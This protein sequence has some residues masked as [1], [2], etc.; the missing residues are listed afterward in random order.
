[1]LS[2]TVLVRV[3]GTKLRI[4]GPQ[5][6]VQGENAEFVIT[7]LNSSDN[8]I[9]GRSVDV[10][11]L[12]GN[13]ISADSL[14]TDSQGRVRITLTATQAGEDELSSSAL[15]A[16]TELPIEVSPAGSINFV[17]PEESAEIPIN[18]PQDVK[19]AAPG[20]T[21]TVSFSSTRGILSATTAQLEDEV[22]DGILT[23]TAT[24]TVNASTAGPA[25]LTAR[26]GT[27]GAEIQRNI[28]FVAT[29]P[30]TLVLQASLAT[31]AP[32]QQS[33]LV[34]TVRDPAGNPV[35]NQ[36]VL[37]RVDDATGGG[38]SVGSAVTGS[39][40]TASTVY[41]AGETVSGSEAVTVTASV[42]DTDLEDTVGLTVARRAVD[43]SIG[44][45]NSLAEL[46]AATYEREFVVQVTDS[47]GVG[48]PNAALQLSVRSKLYVKGFYEA[49]GNRWVPSPLSISCADEDLD[50]SGQLEAIEDF[51]DSGSI[52]AGNIVAVS[53]GDLVTDASGRALFRITYAQE[54]GN[55]A[56]VT[57][58]ARVQ[59]QGTEF[60]DTADHALEIT[61]ADAAVTQSPPGGINSRFGGADLNST[62][63]GT[64][65]PSFDV[66]DPRRA[67]LI[68]LGFVDGRPVGCRT[69]N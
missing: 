43:I 67:R 27:G 7:L 33:T 16:A 2:D 58:K 5:N 41:T 35:K 15:G 53:P 39:S 31:V 17:V 36:L 44:T 3:D 34:A 47:Q 45:G 66:D 63:D 32:G 37:F 1:L 11:S 6:V 10:N 8:G 59:V 49:I 54:F 13:T 38:L 23:R 51:N 19:V 57:I 4:E 14:A 29:T 12:A 24:V 9:P 68:A 60:E 50:A 22:V 25:T 40:G 46:D 20:A 30:T 52:E 69:L 18:T 26:L 65:L 48:V 62:P 42:E 55:W 56:V 61:T 28:E 64:D 21:G